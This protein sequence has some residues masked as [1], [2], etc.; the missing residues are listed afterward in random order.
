[1][2]ILPS[3]FLA[4]KFEILEL[5][6]NLK[7]QGKTIC[8]L[9]APVKGSTMINYLKLESDLLDCAVEINPYKF[10]TFYPGTKIPVV[11]QSRNSLGSRLLFYAVMEFSRR[12][13]FKNVK[14]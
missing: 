10:D 14:I 3:R 12:N 4:F 9:G 1:M 2:K 6:K 8:A 5:L 13:Y 7:S 11:D